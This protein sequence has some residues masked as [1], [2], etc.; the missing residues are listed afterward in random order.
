MEVAAYR[1]SADQSASQKFFSKGYE[2]YGFIDT[3]HLAYYTSEMIDGIHSDIGLM[4]TIIGEHGYRIGQLETNEGTLQTDVQTKRALITR[5][6]VSSQATIGTIDLDTTGATTH[7][8]TVTV[9]NTKDWTYVLLY[10]K[11]SIT[12]N[13]DKLTTI[14]VQADGD[15]LA[16]LTITWIYPNIG[17][18]KFNLSQYGIFDDTVTCTLIFNQSSAASTATPVIYEIK[19]AED[20]TYGGAGDVDNALAF[21]PLD[22]VFRLIDLGV[23]A[24]NN[25]GG[26]KFR[27]MLQTDYDNLGTY[28]PNTIYFTT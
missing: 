7:T 26:L 23:T 14:T 13:A 27:A 6:D 22:I 3:L 25:Q 5:A 16:T 10:T 9:D 1:L 11:Y 17:I 24:F 15:T 18:A 2:G 4:S 20:N 12:P 19:N 21:L 28:D 8:K